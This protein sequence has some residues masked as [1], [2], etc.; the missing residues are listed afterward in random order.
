MSTRLV[1]N[2][3]TVFSSLELRSNLFGQLSGSLIILSEKE[4]FFPFYFFF[5]EFSFQTAFSV[6]LG[7]HASVFSAGYSVDIP[8][9]IEQIGRAVTQE[10]SF[11]KV[12]ILQEVETLA[13]ESKNAKD[14]TKTNSF[15]LTSVHPLV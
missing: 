11:P 10:R 13:N 4:T 5:E 1:E 3:S 15:L 2:G 8:Y 12:T 7:N 14:T 6:L 9:H